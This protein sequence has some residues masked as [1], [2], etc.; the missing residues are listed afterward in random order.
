MSGG[1]SAAVRPSE[2]PKRILVTGITGRQGGHLA[3]RLLARGHHVRA[4]VRHPADPKATVWKLRGVELAE[5]NFD[6]AASL[7]RAATGVDAMFVMSTSFEAGP[8]AETRQGA[9]AVDAA[10]HAGV[11]WLVY[12]SVG[13]ANHRTGIPH[14]ESKFAVEEHLRGSGVRHAISAPTAF[15]ENFLA[16]FQ[17]PGLRQGKLAMG[18]APDRPMHMV[19]LEDLSA[20]VTLLLEEPSR[21][22]GRRIDVASDVVP[23]SEVARTIAQLGGRP[24]AFQQIPLAAL[25]AQNADLAKMMEWMGRTG[26]SAD[27]EALRRDYPEVGWHRFGEWAARTDWAKL[28]A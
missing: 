23:G 1:S 14:F 15:M 5:G 4:L 2:K 21:F 9:A 27:V 26:Y 3:E 19:A 6:D 17:L 16:P 8:A 10:R 20:F 28:L 11:P 12:S 7:A 25:Q 13:D 24:I 18:I 22:N